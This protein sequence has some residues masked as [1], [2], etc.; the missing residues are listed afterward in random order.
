[1]HKRE[2]QGSA[3]AVHTCNACPKKT[4]KKGEEETEFLWN[5]N[6]FP[7]NVLV[8]VLCRRLTAF[9]RLVPA[10]ALGA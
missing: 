5:F 7:K 10:T 1:M 3:P 2:D 9:L 6:K 8:Q 4:K